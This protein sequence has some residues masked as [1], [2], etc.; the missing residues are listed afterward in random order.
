MSTLDKKYYHNIDLDSNELKA[1]RVYNVNAADMLSLKTYFLANTPDNFKGYIVYNITPSALGFYIWDGL[2]WTSSSGGG[3]TS[4]NGLTNSIQTFTNDTN[5]T[6]TSAGST[7]S[8][9]WTGVLSTVRGGTGLSTIG[10]A[11]QVLRVNSTGT[12]LEYGT[13]STSVVQHKVKAGV[14]INKGQAVYVTSADGTNM[15]VGLASN[16]NEATSSKTMGLLDATVST[17][18]FANVVTEGLLAGLDTSTANAAGDPVWLGVNGN[19]IYGLTNKPYAP[20]HLVFIGIVTRKNSNNGEIFVKVQNGFELQ[21]LHNVGIGYSTTPTDGQVL[22]YESSTSLWKAKSISGIL[23][24]GGSGFLKSNGTSITYET[25]PLSVANG[26]TGTTSLTGVI[27]GNGTSAMTGVNSSGTS[28]FQIL[29]KNTSN[30]YQ[31]VDFN[32][33][34]IFTPANAGLVPAATSGPTN[35]IFLASNGTWQKIGTPAIADQPAKTILA[36]VSATTDNVDAVSISSITTDLSI[37]I[38]DSGSGG[39][40]GIVPAPSAGDAAAGKVLSAA[41]TFNVPTHYIGG[42]RT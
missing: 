30:Q 13:N 16:I 33:A 12:A 10:S 18:G 17:N 40:K 35:Y 25:A 36:N 42:T 2:D 11:L 38:G 24:T 34:P 3:I 4:L 14:A 27:I 7:H 26:G 29:K 19:L 22:T 5:V 9:G 41:G 37:V 1:A 28:D 8:L 31:F 39:T 21:E 6:I 32:S 23:A 20:A 15:I